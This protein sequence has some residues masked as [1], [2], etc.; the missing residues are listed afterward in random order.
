M[1]SPFSC[2]ALLSMLSERIPTIRIGT[3]LCSPVSSAVCCVSLSRPAPVLAPGVRVE[4]VTALPLASEPKRNILKKSNEAVFCPFNASPSSS[5][6]CSPCPIAEASLPLRSAC[7]KPSKVPSSLSTVL[8]AFRRSATAVSGL[9]PMSDAAVAAAA[10]DNSLESIAAWSSR[11]GGDRRRRKEVLKF[12]K[13][14]SEVRDDILD[15]GKALRR[16]GPVCGSAEAGI[17]GC[18][19]R[20]EWSKFKL[21]SGTCTAGSVGVLAASSWRALDML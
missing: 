16:L 7:R 21:S 19:P 5:P 3:I 8:V 15:W 18:E 2:V 14:R 1:A 17:S 13:P 12:R 11:L 4:E 6:F 20:G 9:P 10:T